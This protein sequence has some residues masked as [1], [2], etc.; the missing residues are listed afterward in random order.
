[1][2]L[3]Q[4]LSRSNLGDLDRIEPDYIVD[5]KLVLSVEGQLI[6]Y[7]VEP[8]APFS[9]R[10][11]VEKVDYEE[12]LS[13][14]NRA[15][16]LAYRDHRPVGQIRLNRHWNNFAFIEDFAVDSAFRRQGI[17][18]ELID[19]AKSWSRSAQ[20][21]GLVAETQDINVA[22]C[23]FY[24]RSGFVLA[25]FDRMLYRGIDPQNDEVALFWYWQDQ[26]FH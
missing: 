22:A 13:D 17:A 5:S 26:M 14:P 15:I 21:A 19:Q 4:E 1:M 7:A 8:I 6:R 9:K 11:S 24:E 20:T 18:G 12:Y 3:V 25:G 23:R 10:Y 16:F 2:N